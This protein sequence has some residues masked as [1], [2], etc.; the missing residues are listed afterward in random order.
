MK[1]KEASI[2]GWTETNVNWTPS[3]VNQA[4]YIGRKIHKKTKLVTTLS[5][6]AAGYKQMSGTCTAMT[7]NIVSRHMKSSKDDTG[8]GRWMY[9]CIVGKDNRKLY[10]ITGYRPCTQS[11]PGLGMVNA[12][13]QG[14]LTAKGKPDAKVIKEWG[15]D[16]LSL[17]KQWKMRRK[18]MY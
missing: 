7:D 3:Q 6:E 16:I 13:Q 4:N 1:D 2:W 5:N 12:Q 18:K 8:L 9:I 11:N 17:I 10:V 14:L 15:K